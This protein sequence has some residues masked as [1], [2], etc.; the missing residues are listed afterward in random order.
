MG[1]GIDLKKKG[2]ANYH[3]LVKKMVL[4]YMQKTTRRN[5]TKNSKL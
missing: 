3:A 4:H 2:N 5:Y 1:G